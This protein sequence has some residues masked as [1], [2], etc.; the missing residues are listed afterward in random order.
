MSERLA[1]VSVISHPPAVLAEFFAGLERLGIEDPAACSVFADES[2]NPV[3]KNCLR[4]SPQ[5]AGHR[6]HPTGQPAR[7]KGRCGAGRQ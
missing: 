6:C 7:T 5:A 2:D 4:I 1:V 3:S